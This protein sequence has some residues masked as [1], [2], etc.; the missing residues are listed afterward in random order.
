MSARKAAPMPSRY[1]TRR[2]VAKFPRALRNLRLAASPL[3]RACSRSRGGCLHGA[4][5][6]K[7]PWLGLA[8]AAGGRGARSACWRGMLETSRPGLECPP[9]PHPRRL[10]VR[11][12]RIDVR[13]TPRFGRSISNCLTE[14]RDPYATFQMAEVA[15]S[16]RMCSGGSW[17]GSPGCMRRRCRLD[18]NGGR[19]AEE[20]H[21]RHVP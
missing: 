11:F 16:E 9:I 5:S 12:R 10:D 21:G 4:D 15:V 18:P 1:P 19:C 8:T 13:S 14:I 20:S 7:P 2:H 17:P 3:I 6:R